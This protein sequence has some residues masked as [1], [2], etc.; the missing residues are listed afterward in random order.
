MKKEFDIVTALDTCVDFLV[1]CG[2]TEPEF[3]QKEKLVNGYALEMGGSGCI[4]ACQCAKL[5]LK[6][7]GV[8][9]VGN[10]DMGEI[11]L[12]GLNSSGVDT[13]YVRKSDVIKTGLGL[14]L[15][16]NGGDRS[17]LTYMG[18]IDEVKIQCLEALLPKAKHLHICSYYLQKSLQAG[19]KDIVRKAK[20][21]GTTISLDSNWDPDEVWDGIKEILPYVDVFLPN[22][23]ELMYITGQKNVK[24]ALQY[25]G[26]M[27]PLIA[28][29]CGEKGAY[30]YYEGAICE[31]KAL[32]VNVVDTVGA[33]DSFDGGFIYG[34]LSKKSIAECLKAGVICGS[35]NTRKPGGTSGQPKLHEML[36]RVS[37]WEQ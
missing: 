15:N 6:T 12:D 16:K 9:T 27:V 2:D 34:L 30:A 26:E 17:I 8:G 11:V 31:S 37:E 4:F 33:G 10:D 21:C 23:N 7:V 19:Y 36:Q 18:T 22:E 1:D 35:L 24:D 28:V 13:S 32:K 3:G 29:K 25:V 20:Q 5:G 14:S